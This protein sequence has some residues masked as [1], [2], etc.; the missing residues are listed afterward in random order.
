RRR[1]GVAVEGA[2]AD[3]PG[4][5]VVVACHGGVINAYLAQILNLPMDMFYR[6][7]HASVHRLRFKDSLRVIET[8]NEQAFLKAQDLLSV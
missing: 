5:T 8:L 2:L 3:H 1:V 4:E 6:P 7:A